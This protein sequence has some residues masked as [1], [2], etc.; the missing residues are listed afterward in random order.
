[1]ITYNFHHKKHYKIQQYSKKIL[2]T[3][4]ILTTAFALLE[5][6][7]GIISN[8]LALLG[9]S[10]HMFSDVAA[11]GFSLIALI[12]SAKKPNKHYTFGFVRLEVI[13][14]FLNG[15]ALI[16]IS[17]YLLYEAIMRLYNPRDIDFKTWKYDRRRRVFNCRND[18][19]HSFGRFKYCLCSALC[20]PSKSRNRKRY[21]KG[22]APPLPRGKYLGHRL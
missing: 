20:L 13:A 21:D 17:I 3:S 5:Y 1:M 11:L 14:A 10:F 4:L 6:I 8:S 2:Y 9:D 19:A 22:I 7:G 15:L 18:R 16:I 12:Y